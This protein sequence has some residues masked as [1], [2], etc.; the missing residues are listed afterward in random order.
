MDV[1]PPVI[2]ALYA[3]PL[4][5]LAVGLGARI[6]LLRLRLRV[7]IGDGGK[8]E[9]ARAIRV[10]ANL[11]ETAPLALL[12]LALAESTAALGTSA[13]HGAGA[14]LVAGRL[15]HAFGLGRDSGASPGRF[16]GMALT[17]TVTLVLAGA[18]AARALAR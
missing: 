9:L 6:A 2:S 8:P 10:H 18:L 4:G 3:A 14:A 5:V 17:W 15:A 16:I 11:V 1:P 12:L 13:L 7:G